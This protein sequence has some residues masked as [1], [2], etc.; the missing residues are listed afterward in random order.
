M[1]LRVKEFVLS[2][3]VGIAEAG[4]GNRGELPTLMFGST[5]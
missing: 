1:M 3:Q 2:T 5:L 4:P